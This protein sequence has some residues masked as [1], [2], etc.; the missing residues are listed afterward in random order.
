MAKIKQF[1]RQTAAATD[2]SSF[3]I[4]SSVESSEEDAIA[5][6][7]GSES[8]MAMKRNSSKKKKKNK[9]YE[10]GLREFIQACSKHIVDSS[11]TRE[12]TSIKKLYVKF[13]PDARGNVTKDGFQKGLEMVLHVSLDADIMNEI[14]QSIN[15]KGNMKLSI[16]E[17]TRFMRDNKVSKASKTSS[18]SQ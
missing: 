2:S 11:I 3:A 1:T 6:S 5:S 4:S 8:A 16:Q 15:T 18:T 10:E 17:F 9:R 14:F 13:Q 12:E 7:S